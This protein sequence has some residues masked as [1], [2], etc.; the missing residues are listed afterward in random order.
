MNLIVFPLAGFARIKSFLML[1]FFLFFFYIWLQPLGHTEEN[2]SCTQSIKV[3]AIHGDVGYLVTSTNVWRPVQ[4][5]S[6]LCE[7]D[8]LKISDKGYLELSFSHRSILRIS[9]RSVITIESQ[10]IEKNLYEEFLNF[11]KRSFSTTF[12][13]ASF[14]DSLLINSSVAN[15]EIIDQ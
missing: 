14:D 13:N 5:H 10:E 7:R 2:E 1:S 15:Y 8:V 9:E 3:N 11:F 6:R 12:V 4:L